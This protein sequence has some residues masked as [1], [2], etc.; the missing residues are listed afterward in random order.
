MAEASA[1]G[2]GAH[3]L[4]RLLNEHSFANQVE[5]LTNTGD[6]ALAWISPARFAA[7]GAYVEARGRSRDPL[8]DLAARLLLDQFDAAVHCLRATAV[9]ARELLDQVEAT[10]KLAASLRRR[11]ASRDVTPAPLPETGSTSSHR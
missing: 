9:A 7:L 11:I 5:G 3:D 8:G 10:S 6:N 4:I 1:L 2:S